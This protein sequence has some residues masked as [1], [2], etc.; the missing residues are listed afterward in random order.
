MDRALCPLIPGGYALP[1][2]C[3]R[4]SLPP[5]RTALSCLGRLAYTS[6]MGLE[7]LALPT[8]G[9]SPGY[10]R[11]LRWHACWKW[12]GM[13]HSLFP[14]DRVGLHDVASL[15]LR[16]GHYA[17]AVA[18]L[19]RLSLSVPRGHAAA[20][21][22]WTTLAFVRCELGQWARAVSAAEHA[23]E[24]SPGSELAKALLARAR[25]GASCL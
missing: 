22:L 10:C 7:C 15:A 11:G 23:L 1:P 6:G 21:G 5:T 18:P 4:G 3:P 19:A 14:D 8:G 24:L 12:S 16:S 13:T 2:A 17:S 25:G 9:N 20:A